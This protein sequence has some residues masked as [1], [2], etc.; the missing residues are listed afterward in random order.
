MKSKRLLHLKFETW[1][2]WV[3]IAHK[4]VKLFNI[5]LKLLKEVEIAKSQGLCFVI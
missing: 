3:D 5:L 4:C 2:F 1:H